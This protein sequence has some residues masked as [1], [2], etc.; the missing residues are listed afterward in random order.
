MVLLQDPD[1]VWF[2]KVKIDDG[3]FQDY[4]RKYMQKAMNNRS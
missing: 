4:H 3:V 1:E 2:N